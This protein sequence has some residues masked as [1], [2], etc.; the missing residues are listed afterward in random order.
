MRAAR[1]DVGVDIMGG[2]V[3]VDGGGL[4]GMRIF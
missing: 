3:V 4:R 1:M 2:V